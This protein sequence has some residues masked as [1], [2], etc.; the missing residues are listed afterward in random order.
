MAGIRRMRSRRPA[1]L[2]RFAGVRSRSTV[3]A[4][5]VVAIAA[6]V[7]SFLLLW[8]LQR[9]LEASAADAAATRAADIAA[10]VSTLPMT[11]I[12]K[13]LQ[14]RTSVDQLIQV[15]DARGSIVASS[16]ERSREKVLTPMRPAAGVE[17]THRANTLRFLEPATP[18]LLTARGVERENGVYTV[19]VATSL[20]TQSESMEQLGGYLVLFVPITIIFVAL[21]TWLLVGRSLRPVEQIR[22]TVAGIGTNRLRERLPVPPTGDEIARLAET[23][24]EMLARLDSG[25]QVQRAFVADASHELRSPLATLD[26]SLQIAGS[27]PSGH[28]W[29]DLRET[30]GLEV[31]RMEHLV[32]GLLL[33]AKADDR[34]LRMRDEDVDLDDIIAAEV[35]RL[36]AKGGIEIHSQIAPV[37][38]LGDA[39]RLQ[40]MVRNLVDNAVVAAQSSVDLTVARSNGAAVI[41]ISDD[42]SGIAAVDRE[43]VF[44]RF[45][46]LDES[47]SRNSGG[48]GLGLAIVREIVRGHG[49]SVQI[50]E[51]AA[52]G[53]RFVVRLPAEN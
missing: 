42:G 5:L 16:S 10:N 53:A 31:T 48:S 15:L 13:D 21:G 12:E 34:G 52:G 14:Q 2:S 27:D 20:A 39:A 46:R 30:M 29:A 26:A 22:A 18:Y 7:G 49:G 41:T 37:R 35:R 45:V 44:D 4:T 6:I 3:F 19:V 17:Q 32:D 9:A 47:R 38:V 25:Q 40:Q 50:D 28:D 11:A 8:L 33:L 51:S 1:A 24:N 43:R 23:M 36:R